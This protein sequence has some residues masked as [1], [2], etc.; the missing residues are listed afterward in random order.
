M[1]WRGISFAAPLF[2]CAALW[3]FISRTG[4][5]SSAVLPS[6]VQV[7]EAW[8]SLA[9]DGDLAANAW[10]SLYRMMSGFVFAVIGGGLLGF[11]MAQSKW[12]SALLEPLVELFYPLPKTALLPVVAI[13]LGLGD[14]SKILLIFL[15]CILPVTL[16]AF[17]GARGTDKILLWSARS[18]GVGRLRQVWDVM[19]PSAMPEF[20][21][22]IR[23]ALALSFILL[24][25]AELV[26]TRTGMGYLIGFLGGG[27]AYPA[28]FAVV[29]TVAAAGFVSDRL[30][31]ALSGRMLQWRV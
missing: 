12:L 28:M 25:S 24:I 21:S 27:G 14:A 11:G 22:G 9:A 7:V 3:E 15:G 26:S 29:L 23:T 20:L 5:V 10:P 8:L 13:W 17:N 6:P 4:M 16:G 19:L 30:F 31:L 18:M 2:I 1:I